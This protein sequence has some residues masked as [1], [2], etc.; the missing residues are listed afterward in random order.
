MVSNVASDSFGAALFFLPC[1]CRTS[2]PCD[3][4]QWLRNNLSQHDLQ[5][6]HQESGLREG[7]GQRPTSGSAVHWQRRGHRRGEPPF[8]SFGKRYRAGRRVTRGRNPCTSNGK[9]TSTRKGRPHLDVSSLGNE[10][11]TVNIHHPS[12]SRRAKTLWK[13]REA[14]E[15]GEAC[16]DQDSERQSESRSCTVGRWEK[17]PPKCGDGSG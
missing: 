4:V 5:G 9:D 16:Y 11:G 17:T 7:T 1:H 12:A 3:R 6:V 10:H 15:K 8:Q 14:K 2:T 13:V